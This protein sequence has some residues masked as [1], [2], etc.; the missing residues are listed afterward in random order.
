MRNHATHI[1]RTLLVATVLFSTGC[2][3]QGAGGAGQSSFD[4]P[5]AAVTAL[6]SA[7]E[8]HERAGLE[9]LLGPGTE[10]LLSS[11]DAVADSLARE[12][13]LARYRVKHELVA[14]GPDDLVLSIGEDGWPFPI[15]IVRRQG[16]W[17]LDGAAGADEIVSRRIGANE[18]HTIQVMHGF[19]AAQRE[20][21]AAPRDG[22]PAGTYARTIRS[23]PGKHD[24][25][26]W[27][28]APGEPDSP[29][30]PQLAA[31]AAEGYTAAAAA[32]SG[33]HGYRYRVLTAQGP[34]AE[35]GARDYV[36]NGR[37]TG[38]FA[39]LAWPTN[40]GVSGIMSFLVNQDGVVWQRDLGA[41]TEQVATS[42][43]QFDPDS[44]WTPLP[45]EQ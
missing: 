17:F 2:G 29:A 27:E 9:R 10:A 42:I 14:G 22:A 26:Y 1:M 36:V 5:E 8:S 16:R 19:V 3:R 4:T 24:G 30:G 11:G 43:H 33:Y 39:L 35:G 38:G 32:A 21:A 7:L 31:A 37:L 12:A 28:V 6:V 15:P 23:E 20:Y 13:F 40:Y 34:S 45:S 25:L 18:L 44:T 41:N